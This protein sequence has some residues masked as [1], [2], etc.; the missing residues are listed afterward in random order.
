MRKA[1]HAINLM[2][3]AAGARR[4]IIG[5]AKVT[6]ETTY[7]CNSRCRHCHIWQ[8]RDYSSELTTAQ[9]EKMIRELAD[10]G[11]L[12]IS[13]SGGETFMRGDIF[14]MI[15]LAHSLGMSTSMNTN[16][17]LLSRF[18][19]QLMNS[20]IDA[21]YVSLDGA[22]EATHDSVRGTA[23]AFKKALEAVQYIH[24]NRK[25][26]KP[27]VFVN[28]TAT[29]DNCTEMA[30][31][32]KVAVDHGADGATLLIAHSQGKFSPDGAIL[33]TYEHAETIADQVDRIKTDLKQY[34][35]L[36]D[37]YLDN[38][39]TYVKDAKQ[40]YKY[41]CVAGFSTALINPDGGI[42][43]CPSGDFPI[44]NLKNRSF[45]EIWFSP[46]ADHARKEIRAGRHPICWTDCVAP[47]SIVA[48]YLRPWRL[49]KLLNPA[50]LKHIAWKLRS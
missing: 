41:Q 19:H 37:E 27:K 25:D 18:G 14:E 47:I 4:P 24:D 11:V 8:I 13:F 26:M 5:P 32:V 30:D 22:T 39:S 29:T 40:L 50:L 7:R 33:P 36:P 43:L 35:P 10:A 16:G 23:G 49:P 20:P 21:V 1:I 38:F 44:G 31:A 15:A 12:Q 48:T 28:I 46:E 42:C 2:R 6:W 3:F 45:R 9:A 34:V 17:S